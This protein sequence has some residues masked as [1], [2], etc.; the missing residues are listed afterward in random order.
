M[1]AGDLYFRRLKSNPGI[2]GFLSTSKWQKSS[3]PGQSQDR[4]VYIFKH[5]RWSHLM[6]RLLLS[7]VIVQGSFWFSRKVLE[8]KEY[9]NDLV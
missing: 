5:K 3:L 6:Q 9:T 8:Q 7:L 1:H 2:I 4:K